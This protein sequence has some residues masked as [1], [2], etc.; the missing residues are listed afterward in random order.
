MLI[1]RSQFQRIKDHFPLGKVILLGP[2]ADSWGTTKKKM[3]NAHHLVNK[4]V[5]IDQPV[6]AD[7]R[8]MYEIM[9][10]VLRT[11]GSAAYDFHLEDFNDATLNSILNNPQPLKI[12][13]VD[14][15][16]KAVEKPVSALKPK[17]E[18]TGPGGLLTAAG[19]FGTLLGLAAW[20]RKKSKAKAQAE[21]QKTQEIE[22]DQEQTV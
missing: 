20:A 13:V 21:A 8:V 2:H 9:I 22:L 12:E 17:T 3:A 19:A 1:N 16:A 10:Q 7:G 14:E 11:D 4:I 6:L 18:S 15:K 5:L